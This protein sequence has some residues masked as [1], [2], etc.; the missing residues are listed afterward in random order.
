MEERICWSVCQSRQ[1]GV[2]E[3]GPMSLASSRSGVDAGFEPMPVD[4]ED[5]ER[6]Q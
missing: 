3:L 6:Q 5:R 2:W 4:D 1:T